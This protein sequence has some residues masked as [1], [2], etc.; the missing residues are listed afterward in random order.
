MRHI[1]KRL[2]ASAVAVMLVCS[3]MPL[4]ALAA[5]EETAAEAA[6]TESVEAA[7]PEFSTESEL[8][9]DVSEES[10]EVS[11]EAPEVSEEAPEE[12][13]ESSPESK[14]E[15]AEAEAPS[16]AEPKV[17]TEEENPYQNLERPAQSETVK[18]ELGV[19]DGEAKV[20]YCDGKIKITFTIDKDAE[21]DQTID[22]TQVLGVVNA[23]AAKEYAAWAATEEGQATLAQLRAGANWNGIVRWSW[24]CS[25]GRYEFVVNTETG[26]ASLLLQPGDRVS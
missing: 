10:S 9:P 20:C 3:M 24:D 25:D 11:E 5:E 19:Q 16:L 6:A 17:L 7:A 13:E 2:L 12:P 22:L 23:D 21:G 15:S 26:S 8:T 14:V 18:S 1:R 4:S